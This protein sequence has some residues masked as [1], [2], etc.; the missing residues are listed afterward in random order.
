M[1]F[2]SMSCSVK[3][4]VELPDFDTDPKPNSYAQKKCTN[5]KPHFE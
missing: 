5:S 4:K 1:R 3:K 2:E